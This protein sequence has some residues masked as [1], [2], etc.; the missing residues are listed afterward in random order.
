MS[1]FAEGAARLAGLVPR[2][3]GWPPREL[4]DATPAELAAIFAAGADDNPAPLTRTELTTLME[5]D[6]GR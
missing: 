6:D 2:T 5:R 4:W 1:T 3:L